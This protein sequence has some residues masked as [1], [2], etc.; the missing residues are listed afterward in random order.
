[1]N[2]N[3]A[4]HWAKA[5][6]INSF[7]LSDSEINLAQQIF[8][9]YEIPYV[10]LEEAF[11]FADIKI[12]TNVSNVLY[13][14]SIPITNSKSCQNLM[15]KPIKR[16]NIVTRIAFDNI[17]KC[18]NQIFGIK[19]K[20]KTFNNLAICKQNQIQDIS[21]NNCIPNLLRS[22]PSNCTE[23]NNQHIPSVEEILP[24]TLL[25][26]KY[27][28]S[29]LVNGEVTNLTGS[30][31]IQFH[32]VSITVNKQSYI[33]KEIPDSK[34]LPAIVQPDSQAE[35]FEEV[36]TLEMMKDLHLK[37]TEYIGQIKEENNVHLLTNSSLII[38]ILIVIVGT[39]VRMLIRRKNRRTSI[40]IDLNQI[41]K[42]STSESQPE[43]EGTPRT[44]SPKQMVPTKP[45]RISQIPFF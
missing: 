28:G 35:M 16:K 11:E 14:I 36:L 30:F 41:P 10:N 18:N 27:N 4:L 38:I 15:I 9:K 12:A 32:N 40:T 3:Y 17:L 26:N 31:L 34:P 2:V 1:M 8:E 7:I 24:G 29:I 39:V 19:E 6:I 37:N 44:N 23:V 20:C 13:I 42:I 45:T 43:N 33:S 25:L 21:E 22:R 5:G